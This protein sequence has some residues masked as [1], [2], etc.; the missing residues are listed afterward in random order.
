[1][2]N[3][4]F[5][6]APRTLRAALLCGMFATLAL[7]G[8]PL[9]CHP[10]D[11][12]G[13]RSLPWGGDWNSP[14]KSYDVNHLVPDTLALLTPETPVIV[15]METLRRA[16]LYGTQDPRTG[17]ELLTRLLARAVENKPLATFDAGYLVET[18][19]QAR[20]LGKPAIGADIDGYAWVEKA[21]QSGGDHASME[22]AASLM[23]HSWPNEHFKRA[24][25]AAP[26]DSLL[27]RN[28]QKFNGR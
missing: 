9:L 5:N 16:A 7:A 13:A 22:F 18:F 21:M 27:A 11:I 15:R 14:D 23:S 3:A 17:Y 12:G 20:M 25:S 10:F 4:N 19:K 24:M 6:S 28:I 2:L 26:K 1:M 8:P